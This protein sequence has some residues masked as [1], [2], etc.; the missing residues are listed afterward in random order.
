MRGAAYLSGYGDKERKAAIV[1]DVGG[2]TTDIGVLLPSGLP[3][4]ASA[5]VEVAG[6]QV[7]YELP[8]LHSIGLGG[9]SIVR[10]GDKVTVGPASV[11]H[12]LEK[13]IVFGGDTTTATDVAVAAGR[14]KVGSADAVRGLDASVVEAAQARI[15]ALLQNGI[16]AI[17]TSPE[18]MPVLL[19]G[20]GSVLAPD[21]LTGASELIMPPFHDVANAVGA[22]CAKVGATVD[23]IQSTNEQTL[24]EATEA[25]KQMAVVKA[26]EAGAKKESVAVA[27]VD[28][29]PIPYLEGQIRS[30]VT[31]IGE[32]D[33]GAQKTQAAVVSDF[34]DFSDDEAV[35]DK[36]ARPIE[37]DTLFDHENYRPAVVVNP[38]TEVHEWRLSAVD[39]DYIADGCYLLGCGGGGNPH[40][41]K[42]QLRDMLKAGHTLRVIDVTSIHDEARVYWGG[43]MGSPAAISE[44]LQAH[45]TVLAIKALMSFLGHETFD[46]VMGLEI[47]GSNGME[48]F[49]WGSSRF[50]DR[51][52][53]DGDFMGR[54]NP[55]CWQ[56]TLTVHQPGQFAPCAIDSGDGRTMVM[57][58][59]GP[60]ERVDKPLRGAISEMGSLVG[61]APQPT[62][63]EAARKYGVAKTV[64][65]AWRI[66]RAIARAEARNSISTV[67]DAIV[68]EVGGSQS[69]KVLFRGKISSIE[70]TVKKGLS[71]GVLHVVPTAAEDE[72]GSASVA[73]VAEGG[74]LR[75][76]FVNEN[77][78]AEHVP[79]RG[80][81]RVL[82]TVP[83]LIALIDSQSG[84]PVGVPEYRYG[85]QVTV[86]GIPCS[87]RWSETQRGIE[88]GGPKGYGYDLEYRPLGKY[89][90]PRSVI[91]EFAP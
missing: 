11:G 75:I 22:A 88:V 71:V 42:L 36:V 82:A 67:A 12:E 27:N 73:P 38:E 31:A 41:G 21:S 30:V 59:A 53:L 39:L 54:A 33:L 63:G 24:A 69:A 51:P 37:D 20:G 86:L 61:L 26:V 45:E 76:P 64:S 1:V 48:P 58:R 34:E 78:L 15:K 23:I 10:V 72:E 47:G 77:I 44:R 29:M 40:A 74:T 55:M 50:F 25:A 6:V 56:T 49:L 19:T 18:P 83:D 68:N 4:K 89:A 3:R 85:C 43:R 70:R 80:E 13:S 52:V 91:S 57:T 87:P 79:E 14:A 66:G 9:G 84:K 62:T 65:L 35:A 8:H 28:V 2:T 60:D 90:E 5:Y 16:D 32:L 17:K 81:S 7:N 46:A